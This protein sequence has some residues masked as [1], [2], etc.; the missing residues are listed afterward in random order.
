MLNSV[1]A[2]WFIALG[3]LQSSLQ[4]AEA[5]T[6]SLAI[7]EKQL[8]IEEIQPIS[9]GSDLQLLGDVNNLSFYKYTGQQNFTTGNPAVD[10]SGRSLIYYSDDIFIRLA[11]VD[12]ISPGSIIQKITPLGDDAFIL[13]GNGTL[14]G[15]DLTRQ[16]LYNLTTLSMMPIFDTSIDNISTVL[17]D[18]TQVYFGGNFTYNQSHSVAL[19]NWHTNTTSS[20]PFGGFGTGSVINSIE[21]LDNDNLLF[22]GEFFTLD[23]SSFLT[24][25][26]HSSNNSTN[27]SSVEI[28]PLVSL[29]ETVWTIDSSSEF[30]SENFI[31][32]SSEQESWFETGTSAIIS[33]SLPY[34]ITPTKLRVFNSPNTDNEI[35]LFRIT[36]GASHS[37]LN[38]T[39]IEPM[40]GQIKYC[41]AF[42]PLFTKKT[43]T[44]QAQNSSNSEADMFEMLNNNSTIISWS[45][46]YQDFAFVNSLSIDTLTFMAMN[47]YGSNVGLSGIQLYQNS[48]NSFANATLNEPNCQG[49]TNITA[50]SLS[51][52]T[53]NPIENGVDYVS[54]H[55][56]PYEDTIPQVE[57]S[58]SLEYSGEYNINIYTPGCSGD[59][60]CTSRGIVNVT[61]WDTSDNSVISTKSIY[62]NNDQLK[63]DN[64]YTGTLQPST[65][66]VQLKYQSGLYASTNPVTVVAD[67]VSVSIVNLDISTLSRH[68]TNS[69]HSSTKLNGLLQYQKSNFTSSFNDSQLPITN[70]SLTKYTVDHFSLNSS[71]FAALYDNTTLLLGT[72]NQGVSVLSLND[73]VEVQKYQSEEIGGEVSGLFAFGNSIFISGGNLNSSSW[74]SNSVVYN[75][76]FQDMNVDDGITVESLAN[77]TYGNTELLV[78]NNDYVFNASANSLAD[79]SSISVSL[80]ASGQNSRGEVLLFGDVSRSQFSNINGSIAISSNDTIEALGISGIQPYSALYLNESVVA[81][82]YVSSDSQTH[83]HFEG[84]NSYKDEWKWNGAIQSWI[85]SANQSLMIVGASNG[86]DDSGSQLSVLDLATMKS[87]QDITIPGSSSQISSLLNFKTNS[88]VMVGG[89]YSISG[90]QC[91]GLCLFNYESGNWSAFS[92]NLVNGTVTDLKIYNKSNILISGQYDTKNATGITLGMYDLTHDKLAILRKDATK[93]DSFTVVNSEIITWNDTT[94]HVYSNGVWNDVS[95]SNVNSSSTVSGL[96]AV[97]NNESS[98]SLRKRD[99]SST[100]STLVLNGQFYDSHYGNLQ[101]MSYDFDQWAPYLLYDS[102]KDSNNSPI[103]GFID[104]DASSLENTDI[105]LHNTTTASTTPLSSS[106]SSSSTTAS[107][108]STHKPKPTKIGS[109]TKKVHRGFV[110]LIG[111]ALALGTVMLIGLLGVIFAA[112]FRDEEI[113]Y[114]P[115]TPHIN[116]ND[117]ANAQPPEK[118]MKFI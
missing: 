62:Q 110:V 23:N 10:T 56:T 73:E 92:G 60:T 63:Y 14:L 91:Q 17:V 94:L 30:N 24:R 22:A 4:L 82:A 113:M 31:C 26:V 81:Y 37:I 67:R 12:D 43:L 93:L 1:S 29:G 116:D 53:W 50:V 18:D 8:G 3:L 20:L 111:L 76:T 86:N 80:H 45:D 47:S 51:D 118:I 2:I 100:S 32:P 58:I 106:S 41:D 77:F 109:H 66:K 102:D 35:S 99:D 21:R 95:I 55:Y 34:S 27:M 44:A 5:A 64:L 54:T 112:L 36:T 39:Y 59:G 79:N 70:T 48:F 19:W 57:F 83:L 49:G 16:L 96:Y 88:T 90:V 89:D 42:C 84:S 87:L 15:Y 97:D 98:T 108:T 38:L 72:Q 115:L 85:Y 13:S 11:S 28:N 61:V 117:L 7:I 9:L 46:S 69:T 52:N 65:Y 71:V 78:I 114:Q 75:G 33:G 105:V 40:T 68:S 101:A 74:K 107:S 6:G 103:R 104:Q 25:T